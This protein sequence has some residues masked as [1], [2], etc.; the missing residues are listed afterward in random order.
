MYIRIHLCI[1]NVRMFRDLS[2]LSEKFYRSFDIIA[3]LFYYFI[4]KYCVYT[5]V[6]V[7]IPNK[8]I[9]PDNS[10]IAKLFLL[11]CF[12]PIV[13]AK[14]WK[15]SINISKVIY[16]FLNV[17]IRLIVIREVVLLIIVSNRVRIPWEQIVYNWLR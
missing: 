7:Y 13:V 11:I 17:T 4:R 2:V 3:L 14:I 6:H 16:C 12:I 10:I 5:H 8:Y 15:F 9:I 1:H